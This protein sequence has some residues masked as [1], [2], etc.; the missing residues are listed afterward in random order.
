MVFTRKEKEIIA[1]QGENEWKKNIEKIIKN[2]E[3]GGGGG[4]E[5]IENNKW[6]K[7]INP[8]WVARRQENDMR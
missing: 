6:D 4:L 2:G 1:R 5:V 8:F 7:K 3:W